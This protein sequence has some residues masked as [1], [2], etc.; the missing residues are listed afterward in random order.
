M[1][2]CGIAATSLELRLKIF[3][4]SVKNKMASALSVS[5]KKLIRYFVVDGQGDWPSTT[6][7]RQAALGA[8]YAS[9]ATPLFT[10]SKDMGWSGLRALRSI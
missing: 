3:C 4:E 5:K 7:T 2:G 1:S 8:F 9:A 6:I 10:N